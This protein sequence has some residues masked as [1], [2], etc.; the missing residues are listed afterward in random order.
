VSILIGSFSCIS[1]SMFSLCSVFTFGL[2]KLA[3]PP[4]KENLIILSLL[5]ISFRFG[6]YWLLNVLFEFLFVFIAFARLG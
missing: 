3:K 4:L 5:G 1:T 2:K 6:T